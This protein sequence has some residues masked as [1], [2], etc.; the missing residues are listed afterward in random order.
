MGSADAA[1]PSHSWARAGA[2]HPNTLG[3]A[4][5]DRTLSRATG[6]HHPGLSQAP[7]GQAAPRCPLCFSV[8]APHT[9]GQWPEPPPSVQQP[10]GPGTGPQGPP[11]PV[12]LPPPGSPSQPLRMGGGEG[13][14]PR[15]PPATA[16]PCGVTEGQLC[17]LTTKENKERASPLLNKLCP[18]LGTV[19]HCTESPTEPRPHAPQ[20]RPWLKLEAEAARPRPPVPQALPPA[21]PLP[22][23]PHCL[24]Q[25]G[26]CPDPSLQAPR[27]DPH[28]GLRA[29]G[30]AHKAPRTCRGG[31][32]SRRPGAHSPTR[33]T[34][35][36][37]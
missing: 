33:S 36:A 32:G 26:L 34:H 16:G 21:P 10:P 14:S 9:G 5:H 3:P 27:A 11:A 18:H 30:Q 29:G 6:R 17:F 15:T 31:R 35:A 22:Q 13:R 7:P 12:V 20:R 28:A 1:A 19:S 37:A 25:P 8:P 24:A 4:P 2:T 23:L